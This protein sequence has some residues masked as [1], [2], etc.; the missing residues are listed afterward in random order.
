[1]SAPR[2]GC[3]FRIY[4]RLGATPAGLYRNYSATAANT[5]TR[6]PAP[7]IFQN[8]FIGTHCRPAMAASCALPAPASPAGLPPARPAGRQQRLAAA[9]ARPG[10][11]GGRLGDSD[12][13]QDEK[14]QSITYYKCV[15]SCS[16]RDVPIDFL[17]AMLEMGA[18]PVA[19]KMNRFI[20]FVNRR[21]GDN[22]QFI[23]RGEDDW[24]V[25]VPIN[26]GS[27]WDGYYWGG[28]ADSKTVAELLRL[29]FEEMPWFGMV[30]F[31]MRRYRAA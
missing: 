24:Y 28:T 27:S 3:G 23:R 25:D 31:T 20:G 4:C 7:G 8:L 11:T 18:L 2:P 19:T 15:D 14:F 22:V 13:E 12:A 30:S 9:E 21:N 6:M 1:M 5:A 26:G 16:V 17:G 29:F 10:C